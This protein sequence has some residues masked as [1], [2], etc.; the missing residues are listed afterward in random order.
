[1]C[2]CP[3]N[4]SQTKLTTLPYVAHISWFAAVNSG[5][6]DMGVAVLI[7]GIVVGL[8]VSGRRR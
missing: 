8:D 1:M 2:T 3:H 4:T 5:V 7:V 6:A